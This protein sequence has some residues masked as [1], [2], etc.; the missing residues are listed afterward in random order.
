MLVW[1]SI[2]VVM[3][4]NAQK[5]PNK[6]EVSIWLPSNIQIDG[7]A[8]EWD[9]QYQA[10]NKNTETFYSIAN[11]DDNLY[12]ILH[13]TK[14]RIIEKIIEGGISFTIYIPGT[15]DENKHVTVLFPLLS[16]NKSRSVLIE[17]GKT[18]SEDM[19]SPLL[20]Y[21]QPD[22]AEKRAHSIS[23]ANT[24]LINSLKEIKVDGISSIIDTVAG[25][26]P[27]TKYYGD[28]PLHMH[29]FKIIAINN[30]D[31]IKA[32]T[33]FDSEG[34]LTYEM[35]LPIK[36]LESAKKGT[37]KF[38]YNITI[39]SR[40]EDSRFGDVIRRGPPPNHDQLDLDLE[41]ATDFSG[42]YTLAK[43]P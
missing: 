28:F 35:I 25:V 24:D 12:L 40:G 42:E 36:Y 13:A 5:L 23:M 14:S 41:T 16:M 31:G 18:L 10:Y 7:K 37:Q 27:K 39:N 15:K 2:V 38:K 4:A 43:K 20:N 34:A 3:P 22:L 33:Q 11:D 29:I 17:A 21:Q 6:Q 26:T 19:N 30:E 8:T 9:N 32:M 1:L